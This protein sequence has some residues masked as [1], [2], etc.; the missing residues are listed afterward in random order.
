MYSLYLSITYVI[1]SQPL[2]NTYNYLYYQGA[3]INQSLHRAPST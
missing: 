1:E 3:I 2:D